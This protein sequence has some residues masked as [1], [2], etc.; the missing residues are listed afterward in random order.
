MI[1]ILSILLAKT[2]YALLYA[3]LGIFLIFAEVFT[4]F[5]GATVLPVLTFV[6]PGSTPDMVLS[7][8][9]CRQADPPPPLG[10]RIPPVDNA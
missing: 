1:S 3:Y 6:Y 9:E 5:I 7:M 4:P 2:A 8:K 10:H